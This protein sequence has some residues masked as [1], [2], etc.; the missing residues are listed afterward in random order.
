MWA[1]QTFSL[2]CHVALASMAWAIA[3]LTKGTACVLV[4][5]ALTVGWVMSGVFFG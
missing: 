2:S 5:R 4:G 1:P 3:S